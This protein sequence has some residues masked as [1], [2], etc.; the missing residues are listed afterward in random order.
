ML[1]LYSKV[2]LARRRREVLQG[3]GM[4]LPLYTGRGS[5][6]SLRD[7]RQERERDPQCQLVAASPAS[8]IPAGAGQRAALRKR[9]IFYSREE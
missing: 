8:S 5:R 1:P 3:S 7:G 9:E 6:R 2:M 4:L